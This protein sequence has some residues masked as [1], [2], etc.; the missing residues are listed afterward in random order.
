ML[1]TYRKSIYGRGMGGFSA[2]SGSS[3]R[4]R[5]HAQSG[6]MTCQIMRRKLIVTFSLD[7]AGAL[8]RPSKQV[9][10]TQAEQ[11]LD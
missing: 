4:L 1:R 9:I 3:I 6:L 10:Q 2:H 8:G 11:R 5:W 7:E